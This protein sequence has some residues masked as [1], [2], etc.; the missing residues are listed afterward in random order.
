MKTWS[1]PGYG[2]VYQG[3]LEKLCHLAALTERITFIV[4]ADF[5]AVKKVCKE[6]GWGNEMRVSIA[7]GLSVHKTKVFELQIINSFKI[8]SLLYFTCLLG[9]QSNRAG[10]VLVH[11]RSLRESELFQQPV[12]SQTEPWVFNKL[13]G[14]SEAAWVSV[15]NRSLGLIPAS[16]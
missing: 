3:S 5:W 4:A 11:I 12:T 7:T 1:L 15:E 9:K 2:H 6:K 14:N 10:N 8:F 16:L 13:W